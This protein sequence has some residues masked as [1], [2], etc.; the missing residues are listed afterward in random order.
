MISNQII[1]DGIAVKEL[2]CKN[3]S[4]RKLIGYDSIKVGI[5]IYVCPNCEAISKFL[6]QYKQIG[7]EFMQELEK[8]FLKGGEKK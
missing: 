6:F 8:N 2:R 4:C 3:D 1:I 7:K 5:F